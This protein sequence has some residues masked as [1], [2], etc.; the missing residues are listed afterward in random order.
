MAKPETTTETT[1][2]PEVSHETLRTLAD[3]PWLAAQC[4]RREETDDTY[5]EAR[6]VRAA[7]RDAADDIEDYREVLIRDIM[8]RAASDGLD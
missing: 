1:K 6:K 4:S 3:S 7:L 5:R 2:E 8:M